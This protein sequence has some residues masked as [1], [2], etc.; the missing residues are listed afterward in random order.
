MRHAAGFGLLVPAMVA[1]MLAGCSA[2]DIPE[3][4]GLYAIDADGDLQRLDGSPE[5]ER[6]TWPDRENLRP[7][8]RFVARYPETG[9]QKTIVLR[10]VGWVRSEIRPGAEIGPP[11]GRRWVTAPLPELVV[12]VQLVNE[13]TRTVTI[14]PQKGALDPGL[15]S[16]QL[17][18]GGKRLQARFGVGW[19]TIDQKRYAGAHCMDR[20]MVEAST[21]YRSCATQHVP[22][23]TEGL[24]IRL[25]DPD[26]RFVGDKVNLV[27]KGTIANTSEQ[28]RAIPMLHGELKDQSGRVVHRWEFASPVPELEPG[29]YV[30][31]TTVADGVP[32]TATDV[33]VSFQPLSRAALQ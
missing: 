12:P 9:G 5:W 4:P 20:Y 21:Q 29:A 14:V 11:Q 33:T 3:E 17:D 32:P 30:P 31:F 16:L 18:S 13:T 26:K 6:E 22:T 23:L 25:V 8:T 7:E 10:K 1:L 15:Y 2:N 19:S 24:Q 27:V 28:K